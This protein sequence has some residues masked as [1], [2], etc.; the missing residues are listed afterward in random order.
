MTR[1]H[2]VARVTERILGTPVVEPLTPTCPGC[3]RPLQVRPN[4]EHQVVASCPWCAGRR[5]VWVWEGPIPWL[6]R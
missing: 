3:D 4:V 2:L 1:P 5:S 6:V